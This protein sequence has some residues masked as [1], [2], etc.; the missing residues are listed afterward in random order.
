MPPLTRPTAGGSGAWPDV[1]CWVHF[2]RYIIEAKTIA[3]HGLK[4]SRLQPRVG[5][6]YIDQCNIL[7]DY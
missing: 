4:P 6:F 1:Q 3:S 7:V 2:T 5:Q